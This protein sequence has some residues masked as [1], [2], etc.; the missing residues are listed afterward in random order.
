MKI[1]IRK[2]KKED[3]FDLW[4]WRNHPQVRKACFEL[5]EIDYKKHESWFAKKISNENA[6]F[7]IAE[8]ENNEKIGQV[9]FEINPGP[10]AYINVNLNPV[11]LGKGIGSN[12]I[13]TASRELF[14]EE[15]EVKEIIAEI[16]DNNIAS[17]KAFEKAGYVFKADAEKNNK[18][19][20]IFIYSC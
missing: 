1:S 3:C 18:K 20:K 15:K 4:C 12:V 10:K 16:M 6:R 13:K 14:N 5:K 11:F 9:R 17:Q 19:I 2:A 8:N 7:Y